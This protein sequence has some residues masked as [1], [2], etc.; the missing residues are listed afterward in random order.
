M[1]RGAARPGPAAAGNE[2]EGALQR[3]VAPFFEKVGEAAAQKF[4]NFT[5]LPRRFPIFG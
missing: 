5:S 4:K 3:M 2:I 1:I